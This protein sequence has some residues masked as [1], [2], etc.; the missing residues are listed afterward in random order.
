MCRHR[1]MC[2]LRRRCTLAPR[3]IP[4]A[5]RMANQLNGITVFAVQVNTKKNIIGQIQMW[6]LHMN[7][8][9]ARLERIWIVSMNRACT[10]APFGSPAV[11]RARKI[12]IQQQAVIPCI[13]ASATSA[14]QAPQRAGLVPQESTRQSRA[15]H[16]A[17]LVQAIPGR[18][19]A[20]KRAS[21]TSAS[22]PPR[23]GRRRARAVPVVHTKQSWAPRHAQSVLPAST[24]MHKAPL[25]L[26]LA[27]RVRR[28]PTHYKAGSRASATPGMMGLHTC[29][30]KIQQPAARLVSPA[31]TR[32][33]RAPQHAHSVLQARILSRQDRLARLHAR[34][35]CHTPTH[36]KAVLVL[37]RASAT[38]A[39]LEKLVDNLRLFRA[40][41]VPQ[42]RTRQMRATTHAQP[43]LPASILRQLGRRARVPAQ[44]VP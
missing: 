34:C 13:T 44:L 10:L 8:F 23:L 35:A 27:S 41:L 6:I 4:V 25:P 2:R 43:V 24:R 14:T 22:Q 1:L 33:T 17:S 5:P 42:A 20:P 37:L 32:Q 26:T 19:R 7:V 28:I 3:L 9:L 36:Q 38:A 15:P 11:M 30:K 29:S 21:A 12:P 18:A 16:H 39:T 40:W 31:L